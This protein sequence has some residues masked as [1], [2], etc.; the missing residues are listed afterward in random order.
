MNVLMLMISTRIL[1][2]ST[3][4]KTIDKC[5]VN[6]KTCNEGPTAN[7]NS[8]FICP[9][10]DSGP[11]YFD[12]G[13]FQRKLYKWLFNENGVK[14][15]KCTSDNK[16]FFCTQESSSISLC[17]MCNN[18]EGYYQKSDEERND[19]FVDCYNNENIG[20]GYFLNIT[21]KKYERCHEN[22]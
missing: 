17:T 21:S 6:C 11:I 9:D 12:L 22:C 19:G 14:K 7:N 20:D 3:T 4:L 2:N 5:N 16:C 10:R 1:Y 18:D 13:N 15:C 8:C